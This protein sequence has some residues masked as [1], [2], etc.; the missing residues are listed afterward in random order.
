MFLNFFSHPEV[1][2]VE[3]SP[4]E[5]YVLS[6]NGTAI[7]ASNTE[8]YIVWR[9]ATIEK[10]RTFKAAQNETWGTYK[11]NFNGTM[12]ASCGNDQVNVYELPSMLKIYVKFS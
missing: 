1:K 9:V 5:T 3:F 10:L 4:D 6:F 12:I 8:N 7:E 11:W 2:Q